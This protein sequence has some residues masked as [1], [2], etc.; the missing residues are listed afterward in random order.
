[1]KI[2]LKKCGQSFQI[3]HSFK[4]CIY[5]K[6]HQKSEKS[7][8][9]C[10]TGFPLGVLSGVSTIATRIGLVGENGVKGLVNIIG[11]PFSESCNFSRGLHQEGY[12]VCH[13]IAVPFTLLDAVAGVVGKTLFVFLAP[14]DFLYKKWCDH[15]PREKAKQS[16]QQRVDP[17]THAPISPQ[18]QTLNEQ[19]NADAISLIAASLDSRIQRLI[20]LLDSS[21]EKFDNIKNNKFVQKIAKIHEENNVPAP[22]L[23]TTNEVNS[24][25][26]V[27]LKENINSSREWLNDL[28]T[29]N[30]L[31]KGMGYNLDPAAYQGTPEIDNRMA[32]ITELN[33][34][35][36]YLLAAIDEYAATIA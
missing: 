28:Q 31:A 7:K 6:M 10:L 35:I 19:K 18:M 13:L 21:A 3:E 17:N 2:D 9:I 32:R 22:D 29:P 36:D 14:T 4:K 5:K 11:A 34:A 27:L 24:R 33:E 26:L 20:D 16:S 8:W 23:Q 25:S 1:M 30:V 15:D 12:A